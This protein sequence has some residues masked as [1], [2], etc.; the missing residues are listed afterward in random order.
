MQ[1]NQSTQRSHSRIV[2]ADESSS[3]LYGEPFAPASDGGGLF[4]SR[5]LRFHARSLFRS[6]KKTYANAYE[7]VFL[8][9]QPS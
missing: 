7:S 4:S 1:R 6:P 2:S 8:F 9:R 5:G 3:A